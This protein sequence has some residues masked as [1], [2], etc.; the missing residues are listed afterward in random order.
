MGCRSVAVA[1]VIGSLALKALGQVAPAIQ[2]P[3]EEW[4]AATVRAELGRLTVADETVCVKSAISQGWEDKQAAI[5]FLHGGPYSPYDGVCFPNF[6]YVDVEHIVA[7]GEADESGMC[8]RT[9]EERTD[10]AADLINLTFAPN[11]LNAS[12]G[13]RD[14]GEIASAGRSKFRDTL[15]FAG[16]CFWAAQTV[17]V[18]SK[19]GL[20][21]D[22]AEKTALAETL[23]ECES[24]GISPRRPQAP[25]GCGWAIRPEYALAVHDADLAPPASCVEELETESWRAALQYAP[26]IACIAARPGDSTA[27]ATTTGEENPRSAQ[28]A[29]QAACKA[30]LGFISCASIEAWCP[31]VTVIHRGEPLYQPKGTNGWSNDFDDDGLYCESLGID[32]APPS[33]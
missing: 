16:K 6:N 12:K 19:Y 30:R 31:S 32:P 20:T 28:V 27:D 29:A 2:D 9:V 17:R 26:D 33:P 21:V 22:A 13:K 8:S 11:S 4:D 7:R 5:E 15:T 14:A 25:A 1:L 10:F 23:A 18:K 24:S 3:R